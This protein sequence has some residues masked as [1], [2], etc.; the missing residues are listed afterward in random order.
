V[1]RKFIASGSAAL[2]ICVTASSSA[3]QAVPAPTQLG[4][5]V[6]PRKGQE[7]PSPPQTS[8]A[9][10]PN[11]LLD[12]TPVKL[13][14]GRTMS[15]ASAHEGEEVDFDVLEDVKVSDVVVIAKGGLALATVTEC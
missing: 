13:R 8:H 4:Q 5:A 9:P 2:L 6:E 11:T 14:L 7:S 12:G 15:S 1:Y 3:Q 10:K